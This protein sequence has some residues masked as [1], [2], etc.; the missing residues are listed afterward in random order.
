MI[1]LTKNRIDE[2]DYEYAL[3]QNKDIVYALPSPIQD[4]G[5]INPH[6]S[7]FYQKD[8][9]HITDVF[10]VKPIYYETIYGAWRPMDEVAYGFGNHWINL[11]EDWDKKMSLRYL[12]W[13]IKRMELINGSITI[14]SVF[15]S[16]PIVVNK[17]TIL[18]STITSFPDPNP[19]TTSVDG[20]T[21]RDESNGESWATT[22]DNASAS[23]ADDSTANDTSHIVRERATGVSYYAVMRMIFLFDTSSI[24][25]SDTVDSGTFSKMG[26]TNSAGDDD[27]NAIVNVF[28]QTAT[29]A[30]TSLAVGDYNDFG[31]TALSDT[32][33]GITSWATAGTYNNFALNA[34][35]LAI[36]SKTGVSKFCFREGHDFNNDPIANDTLN[37]V[38]QKF[39]EMS[40]TAN[41]PKLVV[42]YTAVVGPANLKTHD[43]VAIASIKTI[44]TT[45]KASIK[46][47]DTIV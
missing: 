12:N 35:G 42:N 15:K 24:G 46:T 31:T 13:L 8:L 47:L 30:N 34:A 20:Y 3:K 2:K 36:I 16:T 38:E 19:E 5:K 45:A 10:H 27:A 18:F 23:S 44:D 28:Q 29:V 25:D 17:S 33:I 1:D 7:R 4:S 22:R 11:K 39:A 41:D 6:V 21:I 32:S 37:Y 26:G 40:G 9:L 43:T 14:P